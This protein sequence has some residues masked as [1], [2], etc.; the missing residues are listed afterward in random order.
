MLS[1]VDR[2]WERRVSTSFLGVRMATFLPANARADKRRTVKHLPS[3]CDPTGSTRYVR[4][5]AHAIHD[6]QVVPYDRVMKE[7]VGS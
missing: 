7:I 3:W 1:A 5:W 2:H 6:V 4:K